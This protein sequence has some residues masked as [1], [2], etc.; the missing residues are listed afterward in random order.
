MESFK[1]LYETVEKKTRKTVTSIYPLGG[2]KP[3]AHNSATIVVTT[4]KCKLDV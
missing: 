2:K 4:M 1:S 3:R